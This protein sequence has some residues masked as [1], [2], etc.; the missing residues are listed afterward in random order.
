MKKSIFKTISLTAVLLFAILFMGCSNFQ[1]RPTTAKSVPGYLTLGTENYSVVQL[2]APFGFNENNSFYTILY[3]TVLENPS[4]QQVVIVP[5]SVYSNLLRAKKEELYT[6]QEVYSKPA[7]E[8]SLEEQ[9]EMRAE[10]PQ[11]FT[12]NYIDTQCY[13]KAQTYYFLSQ[14]NHSNQFDANHYYT[15]LE[16]ERACVALEKL[17]RIK[18]NELIS[19]NWLV[20]PEV[21]ASS[22]N[23][24]TQ[25]TGD[26]PIMV[27]GSGSDTLAHQFLNSKSDVSKNV[28]CKF[29]ILQN[30]LYSGYVVRNHSMIYLVGGSKVHFQYSGYNSVITPVIL[31]IEKLGK[32]NTNNNLFEILE[33]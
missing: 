3:N 29:V 13:I 26:S 9:N 15:E 7:S 31:S 12:G 2:S 18:A 32:V 25:L 16:K 20:I 11:F 30:S 28:S 24:L 33:G 27:M 5:D 1:L 4:T 17:N 22:K 8:L 19:S 10:F 21:E 14:L 23:I 6:F